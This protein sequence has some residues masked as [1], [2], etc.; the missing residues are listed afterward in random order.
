MGHTTTI[1]DQ[2]S[3]T[4]CSGDTFIE[5]VRPLR[6]SEMGTIPGAFYDTVTA[7]ELSFI[8]SSLPSGFVQFDNL[9]DGTHSGP[10][11]LLGTPA[12]DIFK[13]GPAMRWAAV[14]PASM[15]SSL[16]PA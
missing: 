13:L 11:T 12:N 1:S 5:N 2:S 8:L 16:L 3:V 15:Q 9:V 6:G 14:A 4:H 7:K 10:E